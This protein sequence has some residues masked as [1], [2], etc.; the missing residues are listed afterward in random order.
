[1]YLYTNMLCISFIYINI[2]FVNI[3]IFVMLLLF[4]DAK[5]FE[6]TAGSVPT[7][8]TVPGTQQPQGTVCLVNEEPLCPGEARRLA[9]G[10]SR[11]GS[12]STAGGVGQEGLGQH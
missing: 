11:A 3:D 1:M 6:N 8:G 2:N 5:L 12:D 9:A 7:P 4:L 10:R